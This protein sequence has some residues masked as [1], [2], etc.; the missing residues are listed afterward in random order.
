MRLFFNDFFQDKT[1]YLVSLLIG[2]D[3]ISYFVGGILFTF[4]AILGL[5]GV[6]SSGNLQG[7]LF[8]TW[9][10]CKTVIIWLW[11]FL[12]ICSLASAPFDEDFYSYESNDYNTPLY[13]FLVAFLIMN[14]FATLQLKEYARDESKQSETQF[15]SPVFETELTTTQ[16]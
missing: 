13:V 14:L 2:I 5:I 4:L 10:N 16:P 3:L 7:C 12:I 9:V 1:T 11:L 6:I 15:K 8:K